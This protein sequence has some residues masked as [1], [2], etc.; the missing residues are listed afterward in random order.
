MRDPA[1]MA[2]PSPRGTCLTQDNAEG[3]DVHLLIVAPPC[4]HRVRL[5]HIL[6]LPHQA[7][8]A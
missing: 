5:C 7:S 3:E 1:P 2:D 6:S 8:P 4:R